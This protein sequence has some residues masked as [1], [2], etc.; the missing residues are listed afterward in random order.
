[1]YVCMYLPKKVS[2]F[3]FCGVYKFQPMGGAYVVL[4][5]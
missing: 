5:F 3:F 4:N 2:N 1:M